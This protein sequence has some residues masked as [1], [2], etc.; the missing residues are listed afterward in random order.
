[1]FD[2][3]PLDVDAVEEHG[4]QGDD[5]HLLVHFMNLRQ[6]LE[7]TGDDLVIDDLFL[8]LLSLGE[9]RNGS[10]NIS[11]DLSLSL[12]VQKVEKNLEE[13]L[14]AEIGQNVRVLGEITDQFDH[15]PDEFVSV[16]LVDGVC[17]AVLDRRDLRL[18]DE[19]SVELWLRG[20]VTEGDAS[21]LDEIDLISLGRIEQ[22]NQRLD[23][24]LFGLGALGMVSASLSSGTDPHELL[25]R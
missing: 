9:V 8:A 3:L 6:W 5:D 1:M 18:V 12:V 21:R 20:H 25:V 17:Q 13:A 22:M 14:L 7:Y 16:V 2:E 19:V 15:E 4:S 11:K 10:H 23:F 24:E